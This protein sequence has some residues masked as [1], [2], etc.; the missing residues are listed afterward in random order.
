M[1]YGEQTDRL[2]FYV[3]NAQKAFSDAQDEITPEG[4]QLIADWI[5][6]LVGLIRVIN[7]AIKFH[8]DGRSAMGDHDL[9]KAHRLHC[10]VLAQ[11]GVEPF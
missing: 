1:P 7:F 8:P 9:P 6:E 10:E 3:K 11:A 4:R 2:I 5:D